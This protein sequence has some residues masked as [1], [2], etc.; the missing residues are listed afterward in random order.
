GIRQI[1]GRPRAIREQVGQAERHSRM[2]RLRRLVAVDHPQQVGAHAGE[3]TS[4]GDVQAYAVTGWLRYAAVGTG[5]PITTTSGPPGWN[6]CSNVET[7][8]E[9]ENVPNTR[10]TSSP[11][12]RRPCGAIGGTSA[13]SWVVTTPTSSPIRASPVPCTITSSS[14]ALSVCTPSSAPGSSSNS[15]VAVLADPVALWIGKPTRNPGAMVISS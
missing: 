14:S 9:A 11:M 10:S 13:T 6:G 4:P 1:G 12:L 2:Q 8:V 7:T 15:T 5:E 3:P